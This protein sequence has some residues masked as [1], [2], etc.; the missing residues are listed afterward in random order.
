MRG[1]GSLSPGERGDGFA[2]VGSPCQTAP[3]R[4]WKGVSGDGRV[5]DTLLTAGTGHRDGVRALPDR[6]ARRAGPKRDRGAG[7]QARR[8]GLCRQCGCRWQGAPVNTVARW[9]GWPRTEG[10]NPRREEAWEGK[11]NGL[12]RP[13][14]PSA[15]YGTARHGTGQDS[16]RRPPHTPLRWSREGEWRPGTPGERGMS[17][18]HACH[19][20]RG[21]K[22]PRDI[23][24]H[25][26]THAPP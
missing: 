22:Q 7:G 25:T 19:G 14:Q 21:T 15:R 1:A 17:P 20:G 11:G 6:S 18:P 9:Q 12:N 4:L 5:P 26:H 23:Y 10:G 2:G 8:G 13:G 3:A 24:T 16:A